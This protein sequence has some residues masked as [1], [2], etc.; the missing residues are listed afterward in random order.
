MGRLRAPQDF[1]LNFRQAFVTAF[2][3]QVSPCDHDPGACSRHGG[4]HQ[5]RQVLEALEGFDFQNNPDVVPAQPVQL[6]PQLVDILGLVHKGQADHVGLAG[7][8]DQIRDIL[9]RQGG[10]V[11]GTV[12]EVDA[13]VGGQLFPALARLG[14]THF[15]PLRAGALHHTANPAV[16]KPDH[17]P[18][19]D[20]TQDIAEGAAD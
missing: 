14:N 17:I 15:E 13:L 11:Q 7:H 4:Q 12:G 19:L 16:I 8:G 9:V 6:V 20:V 2:D 1:F 18:H 5:F 3:R 10:K